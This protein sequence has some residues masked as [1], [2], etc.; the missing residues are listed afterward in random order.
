MK[1]KL[2]I[3]LFSHLSDISY[4][5]PKM[6]HNRTNFIKWLMN[7]HDDI[8]VEIDPD[9][10][11]EEFT[12]TRFYID[13]DRPLKKLF[14]VI[15]YDGIVKGMVDANLKYA[16]IL[17]QLETEITEGKWGA[18]PPKILL[19]KERYLLVYNPVRESAGKYE[20]SEPMEMVEPSQL[21]L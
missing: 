7:K 2:K 18:N 20:I 10:E 21:I 19:R 3:V 17:D 11:W 6:I 16:E 14:K 8:K 15:T 12:K 1:A 13:S 5:D 4:S 9:I